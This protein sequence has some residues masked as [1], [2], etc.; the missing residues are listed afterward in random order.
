MEARAMENGTQTLAEKLNYLRSVGA[1][2]DGEHTRYDFARISRETGVSR[3]MISQYCNGKLLISPEM[4][5][6]L[7]SFADEI[8]ARA[9]EGEDEPDEAQ[10]TAAQ[11][12][13]APAPAYKTEIELYGTSEFI[14]ALGLLDWTMKNRKMLTI[15]GYPGIGKTTVLREYA[16]R[17]PGARIITCRPTMR[18]RDL[19]G[20]I[21]DALGIVVNG[22]NDERVQRIMRTLKGR[23]GDMLIFDEADHLY[24]WDTKKFDVIRQIWDETGV[25]TVLAGPPRLEELLTRGGGRQNLSQLYRR[26]FELRMSGIKLDEVRGILKE[27]D[28]EPEAARELAAI[29]MDARHG[30]MG[31]FVEIFGLC[32]DAAKGGRVTRAIL[33]ASKCY[34]LQG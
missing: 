22:S 17:E 16:Q 19:I 2:V 13:A 25:P 23:T 8:L 24:V 21:A 9:E 3:S 32:L 29:A 7:R 12:T 28:V 11:Q 5:D 10:Q 20:A 34:K 31:N 1:T 33:E 27:Y 4:E 15:I 30:G 18:M 6:K 14:E 26:K